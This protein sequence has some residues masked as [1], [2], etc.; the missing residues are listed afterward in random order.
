[1]NKD[2]VFEIGT[3]EL[4]SSCILEGV[5]GLKDILIRKL[6]QERVSFL[7]VDTLGT[8]RRLTAIVKGIDEMQNSQQRVIT[9]PPKKIAFE[10]DGTPTQAAIGF[11]R[12][13]GLKADE[14]EEIDT[15]RGIYLG[16]TVQEEG[17]PVLEVLPDLLKQAITD[18]SF[19]KQMYWGDYSLKFAANKMD[20]GLWGG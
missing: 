4:P 19:S 15:E 11:A 6:K 5:E 8:P 3:E 18:I 14:L 10:A 13:L 12:R 9:G 7:Q 2:L 16:K 1:M 17:K 20:T